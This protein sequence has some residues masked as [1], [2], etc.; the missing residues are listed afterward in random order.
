MKKL[1]LSFLLALPLL[2]QQPVQ[3]NLS[4]TAASASSTTYTCSITVAPSG[5]VT[6][7]QYM[8]VADVA[9]TAAATIN[10]NGLGAKTIKK[11]SAGAKV[12]IAAND[13]GIGSRVF[14]VYDATDMVMISP[15]GTGSSGGTTTTNVTNVN[16]K[17]QRCSLDN[18]VLTETFPNES[19]TGTMLNKLVELT[20]APSTV[21]ISTAASTQTRMGVCDSA[22]GTTG[23]AEITIQGIGSC[24][25]S[26]ATTAGH[27][28]VPS[29]TVDGDCADYG[30]TLPVGVQPIGLV[31]VSAAAGT[32][33]TYFFGPPALAVPAFVRNLTVPAA[34]CNA[35]TGANSWDLPTSSAPAANCYGTSYRFGALDYDDAGNESASF[36]FMLPTGWTGAIDYK[37]WGLVNGTSQSFKM[38]V[39]TACIATSEDALNPTFNSA[40]T[41]TQSSPGTANELFTFSQNTITTTGCSAGEIMIIKVGRDTTDTS[42]ATLSVTEVEL[43]IRVTPQA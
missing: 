15:P 11:L 20:G 29:T 27:F 17:C 25:Y 3:R 21:I 16:M 35:T 31:L 7:Q 9:N 30:A 23:S 41:I 24:I 28:V 37:A 12:D 18:T 40:Q 39:A 19:G 2:A 36:H 14:L 32:R 38:T 26:N 1:I 34:G 33:S 13:I 8:F 42:T 4:C 22:C 10:F 6:N 43:A 5:Y